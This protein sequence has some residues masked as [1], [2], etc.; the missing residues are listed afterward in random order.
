MSIPRIL[1]MGSPGLMAE[2]TSS[3]ERGEFVVIPTDTVYGIAVRADNP[4][5][6]ERLFYAKGRRKNKKLAYLLHEP[7]DIFSFL[8]TPSNKANVAGQEILAGSINFGCKGRW[9][10]F[11]F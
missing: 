11:R 7:D 10:N 8:P 5:A 9:G 3:L 2:V 6:V 1:E 4:E